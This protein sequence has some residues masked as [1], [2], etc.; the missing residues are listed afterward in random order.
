LLGRGLRYFAEGVL[1]IRYGEVASHFLVAHKLAFTVSTLLTI[2]VTYV[3]TRWLFSR[4]PSH[5]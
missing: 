3:L 1:A 2:A 5:R 4:A